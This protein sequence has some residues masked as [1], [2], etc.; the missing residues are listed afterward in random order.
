M[1]STDPCARI[2]AKKESGSVTA[3]AL[4]AGPDDMM[5]GAQAARTSVDRNFARSIKSSRLA[6]RVTSAPPPLH[7]RRQYSQYTEVRL[8]RPRHLPSAAAPKRAQIAAWTN[9]LATS[10]PRTGQVTIRQ[11]LS[12]RRSSQTRHHHRDRHR[13]CQ[14]TRKDHPLKR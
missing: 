13:R 4:M 7:W 8:L 2:P 9:P 3:P 12:Q 1:P 11:T 5:R 10:S 6:G 14:P